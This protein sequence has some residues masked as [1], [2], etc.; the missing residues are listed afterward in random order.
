MVTPEARRQIHGWWGVGARE[1]HLAIYAGWRSLAEEPATRDLLVE[2]LGDA[3]GASGEA[4]LEKAHESFD[5]DRYAEL[6]EVI[7]YG[8]RPSKRGFVIMDTPGYD[9]DSMAGLAA[10]G[11]QIMLF[12]TGRG[13]VAGFPV[14][15][16]VKISSNSTTFQ[17]MP[18]DMDVNAGEV[19]DA[20]HR[21][22]GDTERGD[23][24]AVAVYVL[25]VVVVPE[26]THGLDKGAEGN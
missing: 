7:E 15:P 2:Q 16:V 22:L 21:D 24:V 6:E 8:T 18:G 3:G 9:I 13:S 17:K 12:T 11:A 25:V 26:F 1:L 4:L 10:G 23:H 20:T 14:V 19:V 5:G